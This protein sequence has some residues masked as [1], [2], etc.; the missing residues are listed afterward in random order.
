[1]AL[2][3]QKC[4]I[5]SATLAPHAAVARQGFWGTAQATSGPGAL[6]KDSGFR[7]NELYVNEAGGVSDSHGRVVSAAYGD[8]GVCDRRVLVWLSVAE[9]RG[10]ICIRADDPDMPRL[11]ARAARARDDGSFALS[12]CVDYEARLSCL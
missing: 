5:A 2:R 7:N 12:S 8:G 3:S 10:C 6:S 4:G 1:M 9:K 11:R